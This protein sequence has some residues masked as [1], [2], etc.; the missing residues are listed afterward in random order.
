MESQCEFRFPPSIRAIGGDL[1]TFQQVNA[2]LNQLVRVHVLRAIKLDFISLLVW[3]PDSGP[4][5]DR[6]GVGM[7]Q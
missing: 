7:L 4:Q 6:R 1:F 5:F 3:L 2:L